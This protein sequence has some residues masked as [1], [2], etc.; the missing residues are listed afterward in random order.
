[1]GHP[2]PGPNCFSIKNMSE[3]VEGPIAGGSSGSPRICERS[4]QTQRQYRNPGN[5]LR[6]YVNAHPQKFSVSAESSLEKLI[7]GRIPL[8]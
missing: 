8:P 2:S 5:L 6:E 7:T 3:E 4:G 1:M